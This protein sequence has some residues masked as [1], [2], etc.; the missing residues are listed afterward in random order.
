M[1]VNIINSGLMYGVILGLLSTTI[2]YGSWTMGMETFTSVSFISKLVPYMIVI[3]LIA[4]FQIRKQNDGT[5]PFKEAIKFTFLSYVIAA[6]I[7]AITT[8]ILFNFI[9]KD[10]TN[11]LF[12]AGLEKTRALMEK[13]NAP[14]D[15]IDEAINKAKR[16]NQDTGIMKVFVGLG[17]EIIWCFVLSML[18]SIIIRK[19]V[20]T[21]LE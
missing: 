17:L 5:L 19:E 4:G 9:D 11:K 1:K 6:V 10:L 18:I 13:F 3:L 2:A 8:Y 20:K 16:D 21:E 15:K 12:Q 7:G 14:Q